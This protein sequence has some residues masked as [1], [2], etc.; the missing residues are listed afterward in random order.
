MIPKIVNISGG[1]TSGYMAYL[2]KGKPHHHFV[3]QNTGREREETLVF[4]NEMDKRWNLN[5][6]WQ[7]YDV[8]EDNKPICKVV[9]FETAN[10]D[11]SVFEKIIDRY[12][13]IPSI[14]QRFCTDKLKTG[15]GHSYIRKTLGLEKWYHYIGIR[16]DEGK[17]L[18]K[19][20]KEWIGKRIKYKRLLPLAMLG[21]T[22]KDVAD[23]WRESDFDLQL[24]MLPNGKTVGGNCKGCFF[25]SEY[26]HAMLC[27]NSP[28][29]VDW[30]IKQEDKI[31][32]TFNHGKSWR[33]IREQS[34]KQ[35]LEMFSDEL[36]AELYCD[37]E[38]GSCGI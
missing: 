31:G 25:H 6:V 4:L 29:D 28:E 5:L 16:A 37:S 33:E 19:Y 27:R 2:C 22:M 12:G 1:R 14:D 38:L 3:F 32:Q 21:V 35:Q 13:K 18:E 36:E 24:P 9:T 30:L 11:G 17:R 15:T 26:Q 20:N 7:E 10:R 23:F 8:N 34:V